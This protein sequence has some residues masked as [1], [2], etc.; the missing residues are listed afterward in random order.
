MEVYGT[1]YSRGRAEGV[2]RN[3]LR[4]G[5]RKRVFDSSAQLGFSN[6][7][8]SCTNLT[9]V[10][11]LVVRVRGCH[12]QRVFCAR[13]AELHT[14]ALHACCSQRGIFSSGV[15]GLCCRV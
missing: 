13:I 7:T 5:S 1:L 9:C 6:D 14:H 10:R 2:A 3:E 8:A 12:S 11:P 15:H 4:C